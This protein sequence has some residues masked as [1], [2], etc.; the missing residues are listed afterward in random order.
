MRYSAQEL[1]DLLNEQDECNWIEAKR[2]SES[3]VSAMETVCA[4]C[5][6]PGMGGGYMLIGIAAGESA[7]TPQ[8]KVVGVKDPDKFQKDFSTQCASMF[9]LAIR[10]ELSVEEVSGF[11]I[12]KI[13]IHEVAGVRV[14][15]S[16][17]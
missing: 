10:P 13:L 15:P 7:E 3:S 14:V 1:F 16:C 4:F 2:G 17:L 5:N 12:I 11:I 9:N 8:Y 6:E